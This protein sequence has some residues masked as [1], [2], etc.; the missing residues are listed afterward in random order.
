RRV[1][2]RGEE[3][4]HGLAGL[5]EAELHRRPRALLRIFVR[6]QLLPE[7]PRLLGRRIGAESR[8]NESQHARQRGDSR[9]PQSYL[10]TTAMARTRASRICRPSAEPSSGSDARSGCGMRPTT[11]RSRLQTPAMALT[12]PFT[13][14]SSVSAPA[15][16]V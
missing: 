3:R 13:F 5:Q 9:A 1:L 12:L 7:L 16:V 15:R 11:L 2:E 14:D 10:A 8:R 4:R 6:G